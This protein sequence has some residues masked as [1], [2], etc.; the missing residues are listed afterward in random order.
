MKLS[1]VV[2]NYNKEKYIGKLLSQLKQQLVDGVEV[3]VV[4]DC[5]TDN[6]WNIIQEYK[7]VFKTIRHDKNSWIS[8]TRN[9]GIEESC[10][11]YITFIDSD[12][13]IKPNFIELILRHI[14]SNRDGYFF[15]YDISCPYNI[16]HITKEYNSMVWTKVYKREVLDKHNIRFDEEYYTRYVLCEDLDFN[17]HFLNVTTDIEKLDIPII[18]YNY[19]DMES[20]SN[21]KMLPGKSKPWVDSFIESHEDIY[22]KFLH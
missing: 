17:C 9:R 6:S 3:I 16:E 20:V 5:S 4:D 11:E 14:E 13:T 8:R 19:G 10:G 22:E 15:D 2:P 1:I 21:S 7:D 18:N 12:D